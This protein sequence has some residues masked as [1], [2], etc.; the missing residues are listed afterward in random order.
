AEKLELLAPFGPGNPSL[1]LVARDLRLVRRAVLGSESEHLALTV[2]DDTGESR[3]AIWWNGAGRPLPEGR[4]HLA[5]TPL[6][7]TFNRRREAQLQWVDFQ[8]A[9]D[10]PVIL[11]S[12]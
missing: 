7:T 8:P 3:R 10:A 6:P 9:G 1:V 5:Y 11:E 2:A 12:P 4:F